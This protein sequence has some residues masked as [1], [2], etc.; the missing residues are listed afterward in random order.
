VKI[1]R[2]RGAFGA[3]GQGEKGDSWDIC[4]GISAIYG[5][6]LTLRVIVDMEQD[7]CAGN[8]A[9]LMAKARDGARVIDGGD[10]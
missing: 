10:A 9:R 7:N 5:Y 4:T 6:R 8:D 1:G 2:K 3:L